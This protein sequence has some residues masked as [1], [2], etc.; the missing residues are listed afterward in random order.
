VV[1]YERNIAEVWVEKSLHLTSVGCWNI[2]FSPTPWGG[3]SIQEDFYNSFEENDKRK[4]MFIMD[5]INTV[6][7]G[8]S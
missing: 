7:A 4:G 2:D 8:P 3:F 6:A 5:N 1:P